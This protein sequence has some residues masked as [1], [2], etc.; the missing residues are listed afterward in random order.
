[1]DRAEFIERQAA[2]ADSKLALTTGEGRARERFVQLAIETYDFLISAGAD[3]VLVFDPW[4]ESAGNALRGRGWGKR[5]AGPRIELP[6]AL[7][8]G[9]ES[10]NREYFEVRARNPRL[11]LRD[12]M[13]HISE[14]DSA[15]SWPSG[16]E[17]RIQDWVDAG[18]PSTPPFDDRH[19]CVT[20]D[21]FNRLRELR[22]L[23][24]GW[25]Y[26]SDDLKRVAT[27]FMRSSSRGC[28]SPT[29]CSPCATSFSILEGRC[30]VNS[31]ST[32][33]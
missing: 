12:M 21:F 31:V 25:L 10:W 17:R 28:A 27:R 19:G 11:E 23:C 1:M 9:W 6:P 20:P 8:Q 13:Q 5:S 16:Y 2:E 3:F 29:T 33:R 18:D 26:W 14:S 15:S 7:I 22:Q 30:A 24:G 4:P 32:A